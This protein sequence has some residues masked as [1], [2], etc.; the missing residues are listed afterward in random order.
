MPV[1]QNRFHRELFGTRLVM[2]HRDALASRRTPVTIS[3]SLEEP[4]LTVHKELA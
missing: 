1:R 3:V 4:S 2:P